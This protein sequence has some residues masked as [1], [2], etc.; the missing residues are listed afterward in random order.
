LAN[1]FEGKFHTKRRQK[2]STD[3][4][5]KHK[6]TVYQFDE[7][8]IQSLSKKYNVEYGGVSGIGTSQS[9]KKAD[10]DDHVDDTTAGLKD[11]II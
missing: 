5:K 10:D 1:L 3:D 4:G 9:D 11:W 6:V 8:V 2:Y 7:T